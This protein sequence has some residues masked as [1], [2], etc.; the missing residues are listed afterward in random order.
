MRSWLLAFGVVAALSMPGSATAMVDCVHCTISQPVADIAALTV[1]YGMDAGDAAL[2]VVFE[3]QA[4]AESWAGWM[5][6]RATRAADGARGPECA[7][8]AHVAVFGGL[9][10]VISIY[11]PGFGPLEMYQF[12]ERSLLWRM[13]G[14]QRALGV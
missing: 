12:W 3:E 2:N 7:A 1:A 8:M 6:S 4:A 5:A 14:C 10:V 11:E 9:A 13:D